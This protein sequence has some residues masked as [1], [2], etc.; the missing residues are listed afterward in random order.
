MMAMIYK[1]IVTITKMSIQMTTNTTTG[2]ERRRQWL[3]LDWFGYKRKQSAV[4]KALISVA[5]K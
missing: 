4:E 2:R 1:P 3:P 5:S